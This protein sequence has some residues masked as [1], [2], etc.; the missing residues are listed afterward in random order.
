MELISGAHRQAGPKDAL[1]VGG[2]LSCASCHT[3]DVHEMVAAKDEQSPVFM[4]HQVHSCGACHEKELQQY[5]ISTHGEGLHKMGLLVTAVCSNCHG[6]HAIF[7]AKDERSKLHPTMVA[8]TCGAC[9]RFIAERLAVS[10]HGQ[11]P[12]AAK[13]ARLVAAVKDGQAKPN[14]ISCHQGHDLPRPDSLLF[15]NHSADRCG[16]CHE[17]LR[18]RYAMSMHGQLADLGFGPAAR[19]S[20]CHGAHDILPSTNPLST[21]AVGN[22]LHTCAVSYE[23]HGQFRGLRPARQSSRCK[24]LPAAKHRVSLD[25]DLA[26]FGV[27]VFRYS[28]AVVAGPVVDPSCSAWLPA[29]DRAAA[30]GDYAFC[31]VASLVA[32]RR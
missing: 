9:H 24:D 32:C 15:R 7:S 5:N 14:C 3:G 10:V 27:C 11:G 6:A 23:R 18:S 17:E 21:L 29:A 4:D 2:L 12:E 13:P 16:A 1:G 31:A 25:G 30:K 8:T 22:R 28:H 20:D 26:V 19:C